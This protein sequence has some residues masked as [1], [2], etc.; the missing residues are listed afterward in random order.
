MI[1]VATIA[2]AV[3]QFLPPAPGVPKFIIPTVTDMA[4]ELQR[5]IVRENLA[6]HFLIFCL[7]LEVADVGPGV[8]Y[9]SVLYSATSFAHARSAC[10]LS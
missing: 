3:W 6:K 9:P 10:T 4:G 8:S 5:M 2:L 7:R 1:L